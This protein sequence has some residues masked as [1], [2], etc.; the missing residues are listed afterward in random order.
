MDTFYILGCSASCPPSCLGEHP[1]CRSWKGMELWLSVG[2][3]RQTRHSFFPPPLGHLALVLAE[4][5]NESGGSEQLFRTGVQLR[6]AGV[7]SRCPVVWPG[8]YFHSAQSPL[9]LNPSLVLQPA[10]CS[11][12]FLLLSHQIPFLH[13]IVIADSCCL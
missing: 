8:S 6:M 10:C 5:R 11:W 4:F 1:V 7:L 3:W 2:R 9:V 12:G 13:K